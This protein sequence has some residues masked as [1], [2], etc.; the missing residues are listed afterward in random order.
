MQANVGDAKTLVIAPSVT[1][2]QQL[3]DEEQLSSGVTPDMIRVSVGLEHIDDIKGEWIYLL[4]MWRANAMKGPLRYRYLHADAQPPSPRDTDYH[5]N[6]S[7][8]RCRRFFRSLQPTLIRRSLQ[9][10]R[11]RAAR[12]LPKLKV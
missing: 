7:D 2:H 10:P 12:K 1:T 8:L 9:R 6:I 11:Q 5:D 4:E 3:T